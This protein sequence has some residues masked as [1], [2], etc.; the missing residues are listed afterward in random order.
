[1]VRQSF[2]NIFDETGHFIRQNVYAH[3][4]THAYT[5]THNMVYNL[6]GFKYKKSVWEM[7]PGNKGRGVWK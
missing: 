4:N 1:M 2:L 5:Y 3:V 7:T 6:S